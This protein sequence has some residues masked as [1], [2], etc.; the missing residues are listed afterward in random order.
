M[1]SPREL[2]HEKAQRKLMVTTAGAE[3][4]DGDRNPMWTSKSVRTHIL[5]LILPLIYLKFIKFDNNL[6]SFLEIALHRC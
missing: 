4:A 2:A 3:E 6:W 1:L 5:V